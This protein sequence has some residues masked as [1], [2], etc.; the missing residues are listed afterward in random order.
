MKRT[1]LFVLVLSGFSLAQT[2]QVNTGPLIVR[3]PQVGGTGV[4]D[5]GPETDETGNPITY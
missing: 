5:A 3:V 1:I 2:C 4:C